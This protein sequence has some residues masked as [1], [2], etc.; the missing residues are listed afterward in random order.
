M[1]IVRRLSGVEIWEL[2]N[3]NNYF[4]RGDNETYEY[5]QNYADRKK[6]ITLKHL[7]FIATIIKENSETENEIIHI[8]NQLNY[9]CRTWIE[10]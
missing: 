6:Q 7:E 9:K 10:E 2:C 4:T 5:I 8:M 1:K 3:E